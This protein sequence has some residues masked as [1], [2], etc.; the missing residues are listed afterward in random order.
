MHLYTA[1]FELYLDFGQACF[2]LFSPSRQ[3]LTKSNWMILILIVVFSTIPWRGYNTP[4]FLRLFIDISSKIS[5]INLSVTSVTDR[6]W[7]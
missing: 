5:I 4:P 7:R 2:L 1:V 6:K 3:K